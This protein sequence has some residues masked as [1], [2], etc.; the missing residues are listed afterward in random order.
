MARKYERKIPILDCGH[1]YVR[2]VLHGRRKI[3]ILLRL[4]KGIS[5]PGELSRSIP[6]ATRRVLDVQLAELLSHAIISKE[7]FD[8]SVQHVEYRL[9]DL[10][11]SLMPVVDAMGLW[12]EAHIDDLKKSVK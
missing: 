11:K 4:A 1:E 2:K 7:V 9:T 3:A 12:G 10:G 6:Q 5:R 8:E